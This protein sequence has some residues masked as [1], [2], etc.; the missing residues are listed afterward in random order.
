GMAEI[1]TGLIHNV[2]NVLNSINVSSQLLADKFD[3]SKIDNLKKALELVADNR[4]KLEY[5]F[6][7]DVKGR[8]LPS[9]LINL[10]DY[11]LEEKLDQL[12][13][14]KGILKNINHIKRVIASQQVFAK[15]TNITEKV[16]VPDLIEEALLMSNIENKDGVMIIRKYGKTPEI[17]IDKHKMIQI[18]LNLLKN[19]FD[20]IKETKASGNCIS[21][22]S[23]I[24]DQNILMITIADNG[25]GIEPKNLKNLFSHG[26]TT[27]L[28]GH[29]FG[30]H[31]AALAAS[32]INGNLTVKS[33]GPGKGASFFLAVSITKDKSYAG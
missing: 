7:E 28:K 33:D 2:G 11:I 6:S 29:G 27:K 17:M 16:D 24:T 12:Y 25:I 18:V 21:I 31:S 3:H 14:V 20:A 4:D 15:Q 19:A 8:V 10:C 30:L 5:F 32:D 13:L 1:S 9:Y 26:F 22:K 23:E